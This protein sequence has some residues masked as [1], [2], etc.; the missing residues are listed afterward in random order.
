MICWR[1][2]RILP[3]AYADSGILSITTKTIDRIGEI[4]LWWVC[5]PVALV[6]QADL[7]RRNCDARVDRH[8]PSSVESERCR[9]CPAAC[10]GPGPGLGF[11]GEF[12]GEAVCLP[13]CHAGAMGGPH[14]LDPPVHR[15]RRGGSTR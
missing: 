10:P 9:P 4:W 11:D 8:C 5:R 15:E 2:P 12:A 6:R 13:E 14:R 3:A 1:V 7:R